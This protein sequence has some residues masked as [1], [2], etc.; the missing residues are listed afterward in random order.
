[1]QL[2]SARALQSRLTPSSISLLKL[3]SRLRRLLLFLKDDI[4]YSQHAEV[5]EHRLSLSGN[6]IRII[7]GPVLIS[8]MVLV[9]RTSWLTS[10][11]TWWKRGQKMPSKNRKM[12]GV[13]WSLPSGHSTMTA[14]LNSQS[15]WWPAHQARNTAQSW[16]GGSH[17][18]T[19][20]R[21]SGS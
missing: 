9:I 3:R 21:A 4:I 11:R 6:T 2:A 16:G 14:L 1:M 13:L 12:G 17:N 10:Q 7:L 20:Q 8:S 15:L 18:P 19:N 5:K